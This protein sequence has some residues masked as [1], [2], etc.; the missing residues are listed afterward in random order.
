MVLVILYGTIFVR[1]DVCCKSK[2]DGGLGLGNLAA[3]HLFL[4]CEMTWQLWNKHFSLLGVLW[5]CPTTLDSFFTTRYCGF[6]RNNE[7]LCF[8]KLQD[9][10][11]YGVY[12]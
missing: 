3:S 4:H 12:D 11:F 1:W 2:Q 9:L 8:G 6:G 7:K 10:L 5:V